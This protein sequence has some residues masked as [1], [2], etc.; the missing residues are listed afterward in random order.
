MPVTKRPD[1]GHYQVTICHGG[2][3]HRKTSRRWTYADA[4]AYER[5]YLA[6][7]KNAEAG[8]QPERLIADAI[9]KWLLDHVPRLKNPRKMQSQVRALLPYVRGRKLTDAGDVWTEIKKAELKKAPATT[10]HK[11]R[12]LR[13]VTRL[14]WLEWKWIDRPAKIQLLPETP[15]EAFL[16][17]GEVE[18]L[19]S[20]CKRPETAAYILLA[21]YTG[22]RRGH[23]LRLTKHD[24]IGDSLRIDRSGKTRT[25]QVVPLH[26]K[27]QA[28]AEALPLGIG[29]S[30]L[31]D[32]W[33]A[34]RQACGLQHVRWHDLRHTCASWLAQNGVDLTVIKEMLGHSTIA[35][36]QR[37]AHLTESNLRDAVRLMA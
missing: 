27:V 33:N 9:E 19:M 5:K 13:Q 36:T 15:R 35:V 18:Q 10:N 16:T 24:V 31:T 12:I 23:L 32:D 37:Y 3:T 8:I 4:K 7:V 22:V 17:I 30:Q 26:P 29:D 11:G 1:T 20:A 2:G 6:A 21:A 28:I 25:L 14:A 34:A